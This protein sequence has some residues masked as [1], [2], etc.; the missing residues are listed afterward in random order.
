MQLVEIMGDIRPQRLLRRTRQDLPKEHHQ[1]VT[2]PWCALLDWT[3]LQ[4]ITRKSGPK[5]MKGELL[6]A[7]ALGWDQTL[8]HKNG[9]WHWY[10]YASNYKPQKFASWPKGDF[11]IKLAQMHFLSHQE[12]ADCGCFEKFNHKILLRVACLTFNSH[13]C[14][15][16]I[17]FF[18]LGCLKL[19]E[20]R[21][22]LWHLKRIILD[23]L[24]VVC[25]VNPSSEHHRDIESWYGW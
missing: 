16:N 13:K 2:K 22:G 8:R 15:K 9:Y 19:N 3:C 11:W 5:Q 25:A 1:S 20:I 18:Y 4:Q 24:R 7:K 21:F 14:Y 17:D 6:Y 23:Q 10:Q 12:S